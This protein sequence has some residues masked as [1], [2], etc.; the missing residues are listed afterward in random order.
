ML[1]TH[2]GKD[3]FMRENFT[4]I[5][6]NQGVFST[7]RE[8]S[9]PN[10]ET[11]RFIDFP[12]DSRANR[13]CWNLCK[14]LTFGLFAEEKHGMSASKEIID[15]LMEPIARDNQRN[16]YGDDLNSD[17]FNLDDIYNNLNEKSKVDYKDALINSLYA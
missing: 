14:M 3:Y 15:E 10:R 2:I 17:S 5:R 11:G 4:K 8:I 16:D 1:R 12:G 6:R 13:E 9:L 7:A